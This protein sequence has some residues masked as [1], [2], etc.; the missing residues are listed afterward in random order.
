[1][2]VATISMEALKCA[3]HEHDLRLLAVTLL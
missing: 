1:M 3:G 2:R